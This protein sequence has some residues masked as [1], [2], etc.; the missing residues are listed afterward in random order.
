[1]LNA[2]TS[3]I[4]SI[5]MAILSVFGIGGGSG[6]SGGGGSMTPINATPTGYDISVDVEYGSHPQQKFDLV[7]PQGIGNVLSLA[8]HIH[9]GAWTGGD[10]SSFASHI[11]P[12]AKEKNMIA[13]TLNYRLLTRDDPSINC[14]TMLEDINDAVSKI[15]EVCRSKGY[16][17]KKALIL[18]ESAGGHLALMYS[19]NYK[20]KSAV[21]IGL[22][23]AVCPPTNL[24]EIKYFTEDLIS[25][26]EMFFMQSHLTGTTIN[27]ENLTSEATRD[28]QLKVSP[29]SYVTCFS[30]PTIFNSCG[31][32]YMVPK[33]NGDDLEK[34]LKLAGV[35][36][37][38]A[39]FPNSMH[40]CRDSKDSS[41]Y[42]LFDIKLDQ[43]IEKYVK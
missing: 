9:G 5:I 41:I 28:A 15:V 36:Y 7:I 12:Y 34:V 30:V 26:D 42:N 31:K 38:Y 32:D 2:I 3:F 27:R 23:Y 25:N 21:D 17:I 11:M 33:S 24:Y 4:V 40:V 22:C 19:Y 6:G 10:K 39:V 35:D 43:M 16:L 18:G 20:N 14:W 29:I 8:V 13:A 1:M 37:Y